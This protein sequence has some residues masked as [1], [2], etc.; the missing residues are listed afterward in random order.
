MSKKVKYI[1]LDPSR[2]VKDLIQMA[3]IHSDEIRQL[4]TTRL[5]D[6]R[7][8]EIQR[9]NERLNLQEEHGRELANKESSRL[10][11]IRQVDVLNQAVAAKSASDAIAVLAAITT[12][13][14]DNIRNTLATTASANAKQV[15]D[16]AATIAIQSAATT[17]AITTRIAAL[18]KSAAEGVGKGRVIDPQLDDL[19]REMK[20]V[21]LA[22][23]TNTGEV[24]GRS[25]V[26]GWLAAG[27][28][29]I[30][31][32]ASLILAFLKP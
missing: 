4:N 9:V 17:D 6:L 11:S 3:K 23:S 2:N 22:R 5:D 16:L 10:D 25:D 20:N 8:A 30:I 29:F 19:L 24:K 12:T 15:T 14:A 7:H 28:M 27:V 32:A 18:E 1:D 26:I 13:N 21:N 31:A